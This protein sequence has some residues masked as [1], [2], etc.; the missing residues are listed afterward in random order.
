M[1]DIDWNDV[2]AFAPEATD[3][4]AA[5]Q[6]DILAHVNGDLDPDA[7][8]GEGA[9]KYRLA[10]IYLA[11]HHGALALRGGDAVGPVTL[12]QEGALMQQY[13]VAMGERALD[14]T[15]WGRMYLDLARTTVARVPYVF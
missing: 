8:G 10:R 2:T 12:E 5:A 9:A 6:T 13:A 11:A 14:S 7:F 1:A 15:N 3:V 4:A